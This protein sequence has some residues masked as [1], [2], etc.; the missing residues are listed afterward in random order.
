MFTMSPKN[1]QILWST[2]NAQSILMKPIISEIDSAHHRLV[3]NK[4]KILT[5]LLGT[6]SFSYIIFVFVKPNI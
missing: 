1:T 6:F 4:A 3:K 2:K 5:P